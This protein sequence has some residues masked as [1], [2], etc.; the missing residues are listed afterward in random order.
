MRQY[1]F[2]TSQYLPRAGA[3]GFCI[4]MVARELAKSSKVTVICYDDGEPLEAVEGVSVR[5]I[6]IPKSLRMTG[7]GGKYQKFH[8]LWLKLKNIYRY[9]FRSNTLLRNYIQETEGLLSSSNDTTIIASFTPLEAVYAMSILKKK[10]PQVR[11]VYYSTD[12]LSNERGNSGILPKGYREERGLSWE[13]KL[14]KNSDRIIIM[15]CHKEFYF[16]NVFKVF[17]EKMKLANFPLLSRPSYNIDRKPCRNFKR[18]V[19]AGTLYIS[20]RNP[21]FL[22]DILLLAGKQIKMESIFMGS[23]DCD[24]I[25]AEYSNKSEGSIQYIGMQPHDNVV[26]YLSDADILLSIGNKDSPMAPSK[27]YEYMSTGKPIIHTYKWDKDPCIEPLEKYGNALLINENEDIQIDEVVNFINDRQIIT[28]DQIA[29]LFHTA[30][31]EYTAKIIES[32]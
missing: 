2:L 21:S 1:I 25:M 16:S 7:Y 26:N 23:G 22:C 29:S 5:K 13:R 19:Y 4:H 12:T 3:T 8:L 32:A 10:Y 30:M 18:M 27:I 31:P 11:S 6:K 15:E 20:L 14:F 17:H 24:S 28:F 9:P